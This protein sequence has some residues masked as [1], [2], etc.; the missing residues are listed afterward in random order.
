MIYEN[1]I[2]KRIMDL[3]DERNITINRLADLSELCTPTLVKIIKGEV[4]SPTL[5]TLQS[6]ALGLNMT[7]AQL[8]DFEEM[9]QIS[10][11]DLRKNKKEKKH[12]QE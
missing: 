5:N 12:T 1:L 2:A 4:K 11:V 7:V 10:F 9:N 6:I 8:L 3:C